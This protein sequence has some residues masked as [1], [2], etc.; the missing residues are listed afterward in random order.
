MFDWPCHVTAPQHWWRAQVT[1]REAGRNI[2]REYRSGSLIVIPPYV[3]HIFTFLNKTIMAE[4][5]GAANE[6]KAFNAQYYQPYRD[7]VSQGYQE[8]QRLSK[9][10][11]ESKQDRS[12]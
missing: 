2:M 1:T 10:R 6:N 5:W 3:P 4:W 7:R 9:Q 11:Q 12:A 8:L